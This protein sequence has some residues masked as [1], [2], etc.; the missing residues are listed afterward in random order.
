VIRSRLLR[1]SLLAGAGVAAVAA[2]AVW[3]AGS[4]LL[5][6]GVRSQIPPPGRGLEAVRFS[7]SDGVVLR[8]W[9][10]PGRDAQ[11]AVIL[12]HGLGGD[13]LQMFPRAKWLHDS[14]YS[15]FLFDLRGCGESG[16][17][18]SFGYKERLDV[19][20]A[21]GFLR[22]DRK[23]VATVVVGQSL[24]AAAALMAVGSW[25]E[26]VKGAVLESPFSRFGDA[27]RIRVRGY[28]GWLE[29]VLS[30]L[31]L[32]QVRPRLGF[33]P[34]ALAPVEAI[35]RARCPIL[36]GFGGQDPYVTRED[37]GEFF[38]SA[39][40]PATLWVL[41]H[42]GHTDLFRFDSK[43]YEAKVGDFIASTLGSPDKG[44]VG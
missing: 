25:K 15:V 41:Q 36:L 26:D 16:G 42:A 13:R 38:R 40:Y 31:L 1:G 7:A 35:H 34:E 24:G 23:V 11:R 8:G 39:P 43:A 29:P 19:E 44:C 2:G 21:L 9:W 33:S 22:Q 6:R 17:A 10:W 32:A 4:L 12:L 18:V 30:P 14:G 5:D 37:L 3:L 20:A 27:V 28:A